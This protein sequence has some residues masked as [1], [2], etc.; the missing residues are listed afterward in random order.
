MKS[1]MLSATLILLSFV[2]YQALVVVPRE[3]MELERF[4]KKIKEQELH[5]KKQEYLRE[6]N[7]CKRTASV[8][9]SLSWL[10][11]CDSIA[12]LP[13]ECKNILDEEYPWKAYYLYYSY[14]DGNFDEHVKMGYFQYSAF[15]EHLG[16]CTCKTLPKQIADSIDFD[17]KKSKGEC[18]NE[19]ETM[20][21]LLP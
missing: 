8:H 1:F 9:Y 17:Q 2:L 11:Q 15:I 10:R 12:K 13:P 5:E 20:T 21:K 14:L 16:K 7:D 19:F 4:D 3:K 6:Y 18:L